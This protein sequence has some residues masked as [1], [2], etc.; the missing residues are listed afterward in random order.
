MARWS[1]ISSEP[2]RTIISEYSEDLRIPELLLVKPRL[3]ISAIL[4]NWGTIRC[5]PQVF[6]L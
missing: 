2:Q 6:E 3:W 1:L 4:M 5:K